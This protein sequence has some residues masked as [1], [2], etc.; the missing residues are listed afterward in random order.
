MS[1]WNSSTLR[2]HPGSSLVASTVIRQAERHSGRSMHPRPGCRHTSYR[3]SHPSLRNLLPA[4]YRGSGRRLYGGLG[5]VSQIGAAGPA[6]GR[7]PSTD[8]VA[9][10]PQPF[11]LCGLCLSDVSTRLFSSR[12]AAGGTTSPSASIKSRHRRRATLQVDR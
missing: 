10:P 4:D 1:A 11:S 5:L 3:V 9:S 2:D 7:C 6:S 8:R 12:R